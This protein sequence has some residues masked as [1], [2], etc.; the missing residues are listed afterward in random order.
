MLPAVFYH[1]PDYTSIVTIT[2]LGMQG[3]H[4]KTLWNIYLFLT[5]DDR[6]LIPFEDFSNIEQDLQFNKRIKI[7]IRNAEV[8]NE[9][10]HNSPGIGFLISG[11]G[12]FIDSGADFDM[13]KTK[14]PRAYSAMEVVIHKCKQML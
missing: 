2:S 7:A 6:L 10:N 13:V 12:R 3:E 1:L 9:K 5:A 4:I 8:E 11:E 14:Y